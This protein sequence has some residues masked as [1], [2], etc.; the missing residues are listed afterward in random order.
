MRED[1]RMDL[2]HG[3]WL[4][5]LRGEGK[6]RP[7]IVT[8]Q[9]KPSLREINKNN[10]HHKNNPSTAVSSVAAPGAA[11]SC[12]D[13]KDCTES[14]LCGNDDLLEIVRQVMNPINPSLY[15]GNFGRYNFSGNGPDGSF[16][17]LCVGSVGGIITLPGC[18]D[19]AVHAD[20]S[21]LFEHVDELPAHYIN[22]FT[23][24]CKA[25]PNVGQTAFVHES[26]KLAF[27]AKYM[28]SRRGDLDK[29]PFDDDDEIGGDGEG[30]ES[31][32][33]KSFVV[34]PYLNLGDVLLFDCRI[35]HFGK[36]RSCFFFL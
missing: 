5:K 12:D 33:W 21:H 22:I 14:F 7:W 36:T 29:P 8:A 16:Q 10:N 19:Q 31:E 6:S 4:N 18:A 25:N 28:S 30:G 1:L 13:D 20:T 23:P 15:Y 3:P 34:R 32:T 35:L 24:G 2:R 26:H 17:D 9:M 27:C 11:T